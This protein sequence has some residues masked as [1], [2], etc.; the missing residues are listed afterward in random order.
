MLARSACVIVVPGSAN[1]PLRLDAA[2]KGPTGSRAVEGARVFVLGRRVELDALAGFGMEMEVAGELDDD[3]AD[4][5]EDAAEFKFS[6]S[7]PGGSEI[8]GSRVSI[9]PP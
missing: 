6:G 5:T 7:V 8:P 1:F 3:S 9:V 4:A 2:F